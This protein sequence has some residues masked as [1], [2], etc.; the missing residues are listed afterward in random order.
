MNVLLSATVVGIVASHCEGS[1]LGMCFSFRTGLSRHIQS[2]RLQAAAAK[3]N[4]LAVPYE[5]LSFQRRMSGG[6]IDCML[7]HPAS[8]HT[9]M[10]TS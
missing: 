4:T 1:H 5:R 9:V 2:A 6:P 7:L 3:T 10:A 8:H